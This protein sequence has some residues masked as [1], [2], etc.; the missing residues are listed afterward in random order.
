MRKNRIR[1]Y[2]FTKFEV[3]VYQTVVP[4]VA[5]LKKEIY[6]QGVTDFGIKDR[7]MWGCPFPTG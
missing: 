4:G 1:N 6:A 5:K 2:P 3:T 7:G